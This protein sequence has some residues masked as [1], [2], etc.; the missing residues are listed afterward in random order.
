[1]VHPLNLPEPRDAGPDYGLVRTII[2][3]VVYLALIVGLLW[4]LLRRLPGRSK[5]DGR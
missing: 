4:Y 2:F 3:A 5:E 1:M